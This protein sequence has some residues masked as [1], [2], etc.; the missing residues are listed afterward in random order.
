[1]ASEKKENAKQAEVGKRQTNVYRLIRPSNCETGNKQD[2]EVMATDARQ[3]E[4]SEAIAREYVRIK[5]R[6]SRS[7]AGESLAGADLTAK[8]I[9]RAN[10]M[11]SKGTAVKLSADMCGIIRRVR[12]YYGVLGVER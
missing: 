7:G 1:M 10:P 5:E 6:F 11:L 4:E 8:R 12:E 9:R 2:R 3:A